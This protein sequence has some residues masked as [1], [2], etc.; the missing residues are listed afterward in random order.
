MPAPQPTTPADPT[1]PVVADDPAHPSPEAAARS[2]WDWRNPAL[3]GALLLGLV[4]GLVGGWAMT[5]WRGTASGSCDAMRVARDALPAVVKIAASNGSDTGTGSGAIM[6][7]DGVVI[8]NDHVISLG[9]PAGQIEVLLNDGTTKSA[10]LVGRDPK[11][12]LAVL[13]IDGS[14]LPTVSLGDVEDLRVG[15]PVVALGAPLGLAGTVTSG[16]VSALN[17]DVTAP[18]GDGGTTV[19]VGSIQTDASINPGNSGGPLV[20]CDGRLVGVNTAISTVPNAAGEVGGGSVGIGFAVP[21]P[22]VDS[23]SRQ[24][25]DTGRVAHPWLGMS[26]T[27][28]PDSVAAALNTQAALFVQSV[29]AA[30]PAAAAGIRA[31]DVVT[32][33][34]GQ[35]ASAFNVAR[36]LAT[37]AIGDQVTVD[38][39]RSGRKASTTLTLAE[40]P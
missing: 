4:G 13:K 22:T 39:V 1:V 38:Y 36:P 3:V 19:L 27:P 37:A 10:T 30:G 15:Q 17:R 11:T 7:A 25:L 8:T 32:S 14:D 5:T 33:V 31:G 26:M 29:S 20:S 34:N 23:I 28:V 2:T 35:P 40:Q 12:D 6:R 18:T 16:I 21:A 9:A 24:L